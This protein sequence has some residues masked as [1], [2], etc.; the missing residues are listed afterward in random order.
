MDV[1]FDKILFADDFLRQT[2]YLRVRANEAS[3]S[4][5]PLPIQKGGSFGASSVRFSP[6]FGGVPQVTIDTEQ[7]GPVHLKRF[8]L[9]QSRLS[10]A[11]ATVDLLRGIP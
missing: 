10:N 3:N 9:F 2:A 4:D 6:I 7:I 5:E 8:T 11:T 1:D